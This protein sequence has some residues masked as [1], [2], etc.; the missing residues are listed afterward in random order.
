MKNMIRNISNR[1]RF[2]GLLF[3]FSFG[4][5]LHVSASG[6]TADSL[7]NSYKNYLTP[8]LSTPVTPKVIKSPV[9]YVATETPTISS[10]QLIG[11]L[12]SLI[13][14]KQLPADV[15]AALRGPGSS[16]FS[17][18]AVASI[19]P[20][21]PAPLPS[22]FAPVGIAQ[23]NPAI[24]FQGA[25]IFSATN[26]SS[27]QSTVGT[28][29]ITT[30]NVSGPSNLTGQVTAANLAVTGN[31]NPS[32]TNGSVYF[33]GASGISQDNANFFWDATNHRLGVGTGGAG[34]NIACCW[35]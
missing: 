17:G 23:P 33:Q 6:L 27:N 10:A 3:I 13:V 22:V 1:N 12:R 11:A 15:L 18:Q 29:N 2:F 7:L 16:M 31:L 8:P 14:N 21:S 4:F 30:L 19:Q 9:V 35:I 26:M 25:S 24:N 32:L 5:F 28:S 34:S 20:S